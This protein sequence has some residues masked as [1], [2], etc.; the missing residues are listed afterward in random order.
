MNIA[1][2]TLTGQR[3]LRHRETVHRPGPVAGSVEV[4]PYLGSICGSDKPIFLRGPEGGRPENGRPMHELL[5]RFVGEDGEPI[6]D[7]RCIAVPRNADGMRQRFHVPRENTWRIRS[8]AAELPDARALHVQPLSTVMAAMD[9]LGDIAGADVLILGL[10]SIGQ[11]FA[12]FALAAGAA[13]VTGIDPV[14]TSR[15]P[16][17]RQ[18]SRLADVD[19]SF[20]V[21]V[22]AVGH[23]SF[24]L[25]EALSVCRDWGKVL[26]FG[27][28]PR[29]PHE[30]DLY[31][32]M[33]RRLTLT[34]SIHPD[35]SRWLPTAEEYL[36]SPAGR[37][38]D[39]TTHHF[40]IDQAQLAYETAVDDP[41]ALKV[42]IDFGPWMS[43]TGR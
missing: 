12:H 20:D 39:L 5:C 4:E 6:P 27:I 10:G 38:L 18:V 29:E 30:I 15:L 32:F 43:P 37:D 35:W 17:L 23:R 33:Q 1:T 16:G 31:D 19:R 21:C 7:R 8:S 3:C 9:R 28:P 14:R 42:F 22:E 2:V 26:L 25:N 40:T 34:S 41:A 24:A 36:M 13:G 11:M